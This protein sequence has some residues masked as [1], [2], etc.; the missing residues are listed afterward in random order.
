MP[1][2]SP[3]LAA[4]PAPEARIA[5]EAQ[6]DI[7]ERQSLGHGPRGERFI[8]PILGGR[9]EG[10]RLRGTV[11]PG[12]ADRQLLRADGVKELDALYELQ[13]DDG[14]VI[15]VRNRVLIDES[16]T[17]GRYARSV[18]QLSAPAGPHDW[19][20]RRVFVGT[21]HSLRPARAAV[22]IRVYELA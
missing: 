17:P 9:F 7:G 4:P 1:T 3:T 12:G 18:L 15:T 14:A 21:L 16:A 22:C 11:L 5:W 20:N 10:P 13:T 19:L 6:V 8:V 2:R